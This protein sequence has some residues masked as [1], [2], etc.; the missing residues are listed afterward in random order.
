MRGEGAVM[1]RDEGGGAQQ[2][3]SGHTNL[4]AEKAKGRPLWAPEQVRPLGKGRRYNPSSSSSCRGYKTPREWV[5]S[6]REV[7]DG[8]RKLSTVEP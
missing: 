5:R 6:P 7:T 1:G 4:A 8:K 2:L 3:S